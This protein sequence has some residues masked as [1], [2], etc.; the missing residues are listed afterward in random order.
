MKPIGVECAQSCKFAKHQCN[1]LCVDDAK[2]TYDINKTVVVKVKKFAPCSRNT[3][4]KFHDFSITQILREINFGNCRI[5][6]STILT[7]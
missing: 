5:A 7:I 1:P 6:K 2:F 4:W 3:V